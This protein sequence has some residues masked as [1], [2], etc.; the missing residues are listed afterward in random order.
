[1]TEQ[2][3]VE[4]LV[5][6]VLEPR[7]GPAPAEGPSN[8]ERFLEALVLC[9][10][11]LYTRMPLPGTMFDRAMLRVLTD[12]MEDTDASKFANRTEDWIRLEGIVRAAEGQKAYLISRTSMAVLSSTTSRGTLGEAMEAAL[13]KYLEKPP[14]EALRKST[15][16]MGSYFLTR[17]AR[18]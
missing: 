17:I 4:T 8:R 15:R 18:S 7:K 2:P 13:A 1:M 12:G 10:A 5:K 14:S 3:A 6:T 9:L 16:Q 11:N